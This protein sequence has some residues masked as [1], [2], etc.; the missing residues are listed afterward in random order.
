MNM[1]STA[2]RLKQARI[3]AGYESATQAARAMGISVSTYSAHE[4]GQNGLKLKFAEKYA[5]KFKISQSWLLTGENGGSSQN[6]SQIGM[7]PVVGRVSAGVPLNVET[8]EQEWLEMH[9]KP[10]VPSAS[11]YPAEW[12]YSFEV[13]G[14]S[15]NKIAPHGSILI[16]LDIAN[17][18]YSVQDGDLVIVEHSMF[19]GQ[20]IDRTAKRIR[21]TSSGYDLWPESTNPNFSEPIPINGNE[22]TEA[23]AIKAKVLWILTRP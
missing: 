14:D 15:L 11:S 18:G 4:N 19:D 13:D 7:V 3:D 10:T 20:A 8:V 17:S 9:D 21:R 5:R 23:Y 16:C 6:T 2:Q 1:K 22:E 12:Q